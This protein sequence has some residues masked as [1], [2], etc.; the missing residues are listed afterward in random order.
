MDGVFG[1]LLRRI[2]DT[3]GSVFYIHRTGTLVFDCRQQL[4]IAR[5]AILRPRLDTQRENSDPL[6]G[7]DAFQVT[8][9][10]GIRIA[11]FPRNRN[12]AGRALCTVIIHR[13]DISQRR[14]ERIGQIGVDTGRS[15]LLE[16]QFDGL[17]V[18]IFGI[19]LHRPAAQ[20]AFGAQE[21]HLRGIH[22]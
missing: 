9:L 22:P 5:A 21:R 13:I 3:A 1:I 6:L 8:L 16:R 15:P 19:A 4:G 14:T 20:G 17:F 12:R 2:R 18:E 10:D 7:D 11:R